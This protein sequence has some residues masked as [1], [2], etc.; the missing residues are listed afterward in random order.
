MEN[1]NPYRYRPQEPSL[2]VKMWRKL[3]ADVRMNLEFNVLPEDPRDKL[4]PN[5]E[6]QLE[7]GLAWYRDIVGH[8]VFYHPWWLAA[9]ALLSVILAYAV[10]TILGI[11]ILFAALPL[12]LIAGIVCLGIYQH[13]E[14]LQWRLVKTNARLVISIPVHHRWPLVDNI[15]LKGLPSVVDTNWSKQPIWRLFQ[16]ITG[17]RDLYISLIPMQFDERSAVVR[18]ALIMPDVMP[19]DVWALKEQVFTVAVP[20]PQRVVFDSPQPIVIEEAQPES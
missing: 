16:A 12:A 15:E 19:D 2:L 10:V 5:E 17:A 8:L 6:V 9:G 20:R 4:L 18:N 11:D 3:P 1:E 13:V 14:H 7:I